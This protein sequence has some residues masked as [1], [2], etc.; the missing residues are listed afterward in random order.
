METRVKDEEGSN[1]NVPVVP[2]RT[3]RHC[4]EVCVDGAAKAGVAPGKIVLLEGRSG[5]G[6]FGLKHVEEPD[7]ARAIAG[8]GYVTCKAFVFDVASNWT[9][10]HKGETDRIT[11]AVQ[12]AGGFNALVLH[13]QE[14]S[15][16][17]VVTALPF[18]RPKEPLVFQKE[19][20]GKS[21][22]RQT[23]AVRP[24]FE[25]L[26]LPKPDKGS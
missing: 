18:R 11:V 6:G 13:W 7:R 19:R 16:W 26:T 12:C 15:F 23:L 24:R 20:P 2:N 1:A 4:G 21:E 14:N 5:Q 17:S 10:L 25:T 22:P 9:H 3:D 8:R